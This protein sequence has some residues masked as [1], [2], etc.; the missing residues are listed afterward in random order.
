MNAPLRYGWVIVLVVGAVGPQRATRAAALDS[1]FTYQGQVLKDGVPYTGSCDFQFRLFDAESGGTAVS[2]MGS[3]GG[4]PVANGLFTV[5]QNFGALPFSGADRW[6]EVAVRCPD[7]SGPY[8]TLS[9]RQQLTATPYALYA[10]S[11]GSAG[12]LVC[13]A[14]VSETDIAGGAVGAVA[15]VNGAVTGEKIAAGHIL[16]DHTSFN[17]ANSSEKGGP[18][19]DLTCNGCVGSTDLA[20]GA[21]GSQALADGAITSA[22]I[23]ANSISSSDV[24]FSYAASGS[25]GGPAVDLA[26]SGCVAGSDLADGAV[27]T[28]KIVPGANGQVLATAGGTVLWQTSAAGDISAVNTPAGSGLSGGATAGDVTL[29]VNFTTAGGSNGSAFAAARG[30]HTHYGAAW[31]GAATTGLAVVTTASAALVTGLYGR[32]GSGASTGP[33]SPGAGVWG[34]SANG[35]GV[36]GTSATGPGVKATSTSGPGVDGASQGGYG[37]SGRSTNNSG[38]YGF[39]PGQRGVEGTSTNGTGVVGEHVGTTGTAPGVSGITDSATGAVFPFTDPAA[40]GVLGRVTATSPGAYSTGVRG[41]NA[42]TAGNGI[43]VFG[44]HAG[45]GWG[46]YGTAVTGTGIYGRVTGTSGIGVRADGNGSNTTALYIANGAIKVPAAAAAPVF[47]H[48]AD[49][50][51]FFV[52][53]LGGANGTTIDHPLAN[54]DP[55]AVLI[56]TGRSRPRPFPLIGWESAPLV[57]VNYDT[58]A[59]R[60]R[61]VSVGSNMEIGDEFNVLV[62]EQ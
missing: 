42:G 56:V 8:T 61:L 39:S 34:D 17:Y 12:D 55:N 47:R 21:V 22:K 13:T 20:D 52:D 57:T 45:G 40:A 23:F 16:P 35:S 1:L 62:V 36:E 14:C 43:G 27:G 15:L 46:V 10:A 32:Q 38:V 7:G 37:V 48:A 33:I 11:S 53:V 51:N 49:A 28:A 29:A 3:A 50:G 60:W 2:E 24:L 41:I 9:P 25:K 26:C 19:I 31:T 5:G 44:S 4:L 30:D 59:G 54:G 6:L 18:A 58:N